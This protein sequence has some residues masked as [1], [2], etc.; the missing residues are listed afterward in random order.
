M[1]T[2]K[3]ARNIS[4]TIPEVTL[5]V[6]IAPVREVDPAA[7]PAVSMMLDTQA[8]CGEMGQPCEVEV[9]S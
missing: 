8:S 6:E 5:P 1:K 4:T 7:P 9:C 2:I 3:V